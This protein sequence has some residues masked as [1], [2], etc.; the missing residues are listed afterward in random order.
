MKKL[1]LF[2]VV[3]L[4][5]LISTYAQGPLKKGEIQINAGVGLG[6]HSIPVYGGV[7]FG[8]GNDFSLGLET[9]YRN[10][11]DHYSVWSFS[12]NANYHFNR[13]LSIPRSFDFYAGVNLGAY[14]Y[15]YD[16]Y[17]YDDYYH[18][19]EL[20]P[21]GVGLHVGGRFYLTP[22]VALNLEIGGGNAFS[23]GKFG[24]SFRL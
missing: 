15:S 14:F 5:A 8:I 19:D 23:G 11:N 6:E 1:A 10:R 18:D 3:M 21:L 17:Y 9:S 16:D 20:S 2:I 7:D 13:I 22:A 24:V 4:F 12:G